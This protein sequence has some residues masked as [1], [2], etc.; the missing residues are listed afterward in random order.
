MPLYFY[1][2]RRQA[3]ACGMGG[4]CPKKVHD[5][6]QHPAFV[7]EP[8]LVKPLFVFNATCRSSD[9]LSWVGV[10]V[11][12]QKWQHFA[13]WDSDVQLENSSAKLLSELNICRN[14]PVSD[15]DT[16]QLNW[17]FR[18]L[19]GKKGCVSCVFLY[20]SRACW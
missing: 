4:N 15:I 14:S 12:C 9:L 17:R 5:L 8:V 3:L 16:F 13:F 11:W 20:C 7:N 6:I 10:V 19:T 2:R 18:H 1:S